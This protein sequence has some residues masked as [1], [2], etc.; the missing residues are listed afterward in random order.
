VREW[1]RRVAAF[2]RFWWRTS[3]RIDGAIPGHSV[4]DRMRHLDH[5]LRLVKSERTTEERLTELEDYANVPLIVRVRLE[6]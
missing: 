6:R 1:V 3:Q 2:V 5:T 4:P